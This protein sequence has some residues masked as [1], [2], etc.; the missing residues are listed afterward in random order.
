MLEI[1]SCAISRT[2]QSFWSVN[3]SKKAQCPQEFARRAN[4]TH[5]AARLSHRRFV[6]LPDSFHF[7]AIV[8]ILPV[9][10]SIFESDVPRC[11]Y[12]WALLLECTVWMAVLNAIDKSH[13]HLAIPPHT[14]NGTKRGQKLSEWRQFF[15]R[16][17]FSNVNIIFCTIDFAYQQCIE[18]KWGAI[19]GN[20]CSGAFRWFRASQRMKSSSL[21]VVVE[22]LGIL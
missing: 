4:S 21:F 11:I 12:M 5:S 22:S 19:V 1:P 16:C 15:L 6:Q 9:I 18:I 20:G 17:L 10:L 14:K 8:T 2:F 13:V 3:Q 7:S